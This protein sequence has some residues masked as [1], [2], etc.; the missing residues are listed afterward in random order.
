MAVVKDIVVEHS[1]NLI[2][3]FQTE[4]F[5]KIEDIIEQIPVGSAEYATIENWT[6]TGPTAVEVM[7]GSGVVVLKCVKIEP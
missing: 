6:I 7:E 1:V 4:D 3:L 2:V 5:T